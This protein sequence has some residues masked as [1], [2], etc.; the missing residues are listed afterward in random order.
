M[1]GTVTQLTRDIMRETLTFAGED[2]AAL[3][4][5]VCILSSH[6]LICGQDAVANSCIREFSILCETESVD[7]R[8][9][10]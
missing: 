3:I 9:K 4:D 8:A 10:F 1:W 7:R 2:D 5:M 6:S